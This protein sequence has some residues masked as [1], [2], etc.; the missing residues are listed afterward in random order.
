MKLNSNS[1]RSGLAFA[2]LW[3]GLTVCAQ[4]DFTLE[5]A[6]A[7]RNQVPVGGTVTTAA[8]VFDEEGNVLVYGRFAGA[9]DFDLGPGEYWAASNGNSDL[10]VAKY[11]SSGA[12]IFAHA[13]G[14]TG[15]EIAHDLSL[16]PSG[17]ILI[18]G[19][20]S[21]TVDFDPGPGTLSLTSAG[22]FDAFVAKYT[23]EGNVIFANR[24]GGTSADICFGVT[25]SADG[26]VSA[27]IQYT[28]TV[29]LDPGAGTFNVSSSGGRDIAMVRYA[30]DGSF[31]NGFKIGST[32]DDFPV[33]IA[34]DS[35]NN[36]YI[37]GYVSST[38]DFD[39]SPGSFTI[40]TAGN[41]DIFIAKYSSAGTLI[42]ANVLGSTSADQCQMISLD[43]AGN[44]LIT[45][46]FNGVVD[47][48]PGAGVNLLASAGASD[49]FIAKYTSTGDYI[50]A[51]RIG[52]SGSESGED[53]HYDAFSN[54]ILVTGFFNGT[55][56]FDP[57]A[58]AWPIDSGGGTDAFLLRLSESGG[59]V[60]AF[61]QIGI[62][63]GQGTSVATDSFG[64]IAL[65]GY[66]SQSV[67]VD[68]YP[69]VVTLSAAGTSLTGQ[70]VCYT[71]SQSYLWGGSFG[72]Y[73][74]TEHFDRARSITSDASGNTYATGTYSGNF[75][76]DPGPSEFILTGTS[77]PNQNIYVAKYNATG[78]LVFGFG[79]A[80]S[81]SNVEEGYSI[82]VNDL[83][84]I[85]IAGSFSGILDF[86]PGP[87]VFNLQSVD[88]SDAFLARY[89]ADGTFISAFRFS[90]NLI[91][92]MV[93]TPTQEILLT[94]GFYSTADL[95]PGPGLFSVTSVSGTTDAYVIRLAP[96]GSFIS[97]FTWGGTSFDIGYDVAQGTDGRWAVTGFSSGSTLDFDLGAGV[98]NQTV[99][100]GFLAV[101]DGG[102]QLLFNRT[103][104][105]T[106]NTSIPGVPGYA[107]S[108]DQNNNLYWAGSHTGSDPGPGFP[109]FSSGGNDVFVA[110]YSDVG[111]IIWA[112]S[113]GGA[114]A[115]NLRDL[116]VLPSGNYFVTGQFTGTVDFDPGS[117]VAQLVSNGA[118]D[119]FLGY[120]SAEGALMSLGSF[121]GVLDDIP[122]SLALHA[123][124][125]VSVSGEFQGVVDFDTGVGVQTRAGLNRTEAF[126]ARY[127]TASVA[128]FAITAA[129]SEGATITPSGQVNVAQGGSQTFTIA[130]IPGYCISDVLVNGLSQGI[131]ADYTFS[132][133]TQTHT[134]E[135]VA[136]PS[137][138]WYAD[139]DGDGFA[140]FTNTVQACTPPPG[141]LAFPSDCDDTDADI[142]PD[143]PEVCNGL[144]DNCNEMLEEGLVFTTYFVDGDG[145]GFGASP[146]IPVQVL[147]EGFEDV[148]ALFANGWSNQNLTEPIGP[149][150]Y[151][152][153]LT[154]VFSAH[155][156]SPASYVAVNFNSGT[157]VSVTS[158]WLFTP[159]L[160]LSNG[161]QFRFWTKSEDNLL[162]PDR[163]QVRMSTN[164]NSTNVGSNPFSTGDFSI[165]LLD[166][167]PNYLPD[168]YPFEWTEYVVTIVG[169]NAPVSGRIAFRYFG[170][171][172]GP[173]G[174]NL[175][176]IGID[177]LSYSLPASG[178]AISCS[179]APTGYVANSDD[180][181]DSNA[182]I[183]P[184]LAW[185]LDSDGDGFAGETV[186]SCISPGAGYTISV[187]P[188]GDC[189]DNNANIRPG[190]AELCNGVDDDCDGLIDEGCGTGNDVIGGALPLPNS[191]V[192]ICTSVNG[193]LAGAAADPI[194]GA[195]VVTGEDVWYFF[196][197]ITSAVSIECATSEANVL[198]E[199]RTTG[200]TVVDVENAV[201]TVGTERM[202]VNGLTIGQTYYLR[203][204]NFDSTQGEGAF[205]L[206]LRPL[207]AAQC[208][209][210]PGAYN[211]CST[212]K[213]THVGAN[214]YNFTF[215]P[216]GPAPAVFGSTTNG[217]TKIQLGN[218]AGITYGTTYQVTIDAVYNLTDG[219]GSPEVFVVSYATAPCTMVTAPHLDPDLRSSD[220]SPNIRYKNSII[221]ADRWVCGA[222]SME[223]EFTQQ[224][225]ITGLS[226]TVD[227]NAPTRFINL[228]PIA[229][230]VPGA[231][232]LVRIRPMFGAV[233]GDWGPDSQTL[234]IAGPASMA[235]EE[236]M[237][238]LETAEGIQAN[239]FPNPTQ[240]DRINL[241]VDGAEGNL[242][243]RIYD[244][245]GR[246]VW[247]GNRVSEG[248]LRTT[249]EMGQTLEGGVY[250]LVIIAGEQRVTKR[251][252]VAQ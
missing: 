208:N 160:S 102:N 122:F 85:W 18:S 136:I 86:D 245:L 35:D 29:D 170:E 117:G 173:D 72:G 247:N 111:N 100:G 19:Y 104:S 179:G 1:I 24:T 195:T 107:V 224:T 248:S 246:E 4:D 52:G 206:C 182:A 158:N 189:D 229:G 66:F 237:V 123:D 252:V 20:F 89:A 212:F 235:A 53:V 26:T 14:G 214:Q 58:G 155:T 21:V 27:V 93:I 225:P 219:A 239:L 31:L 168:G 181:D 154:S 38:V 216:D 84:E 240:G 119:V 114:G 3:T 238:A 129:A 2:M 167:N 236:E 88:A 124:E 207:R 83:G 5:W 209:L 48:D 174:P 251:F 103:P 187:L 215:D 250:E 13:I 198:L 7:L 43:N 244:A 196:T 139:A 175:N 41:F 68:F 9:V 165:L 185:Y 96:D 164:G 121:G 130:A 140:G 22:G 145:D 148:S 10:F 101:Y 152:Q 243:I 71:A 113:L 87:G 108:F 28:G 116:S 211:I 49:V 143:A 77:S 98:Q 39:P 126:I 220:A 163:L 151:F 67:D 23:S 62:G 204:R 45:G 197:S 203:V 78:G 249:L 231:T 138:T 25:S 127:A 172:S 91:T 70:L 90:F 142:N 60:G 227:N 118:A 65:C 73:P 57:G 153:G 241:A 8:T 112:Q 56:D 82:G 80:S 133:V 59:F 150:S 159:E 156:G 94:G 125:S 63:S 137:P 105:G 205:T 115:D 222:T 146:G 81:N 16:D 79:L 51:G 50:W 157:G 190:A 12:F 15:A 42:F 75:D 131:L 97:A 210:V 99:S 202:N 69:P 162:F 230:I 194:P 106:V 193:S 192:G 92:N 147:S 177:D 178:T 47:F 44:I 37:A 191:P 61:A 184:G 46:S 242:I 221:A 161:A 234:I 132:N 74:T 232:Y 183:N 213:S 186:Q 201:S 128:E 11:S 95:D 110:R 17:N 64:N 134:I 180:C 149:S 120:F 169:L 55:A 33:D 6:N 166:I 40:P 176:Y 199:L 36:I 30:S 228:Y 109:L 233:G 135:A 218:V 34:V 217:I 32:A 171:D 76:L 200:G 54:E 223:F 144:D 188:L 226:F 141:Y